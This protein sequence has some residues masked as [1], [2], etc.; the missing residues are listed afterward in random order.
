M[1]LPVDWLV[2]FFFLI[3]ISI[4]IL[5][6]EIQSKFKWR[7]KAFKLEDEI[8]KLKTQISDPTP[9][10]SELNITLEE[11]KSKLTYKQFKI[12][13]YTVE[14]LSSKEIGEIFGTSPLTIDSHIREILKNLN[15]NKR[16]QLSG[17]LFKQIKNIIE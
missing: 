10:K 1:S 7:D 17:V 12:F 8:Q 9:L 13:L 5:V 11:I 2:L 16:S 4:F 14:G 3:L 15:V 6:F